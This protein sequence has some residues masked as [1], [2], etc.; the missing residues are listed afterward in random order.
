MST[1]FHAAIIAGAAVFVAAWATSVR[2][3]DVSKV[4][5]AVID[6]GGVSCPRDATVTA[7]AHTNEPGTV[8]F[9]IRNDS[10]GKTGELSA[11]AVKGPAGNYL[12]TYTQTFKI[13]A[14]VDINYMAEAVGQ[15]KLSDWVSFKATCGPQVRTK[16]SSAEPPAKKTPAKKTSDVNKD[17]PTTKGPDAEPPAQQTSTGKPASSGKPTGAGKPT[18]GPGKPVEQCGDAISV[19]RLAAVTRIGGKATAEAG[20]AQEVKKHYPDNWGNWN[21][22]KDRNTSCKFAGTWNCT[23][24]ARPCAP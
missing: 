21:N 10:G 8:K 23:A 14:D 12:A 15:G 7:W 5:L 1:V 3:L 9:V 11:A 18:A 24:S 4:E 13:T 20:W 16:K 2:A 17:E 6:N 19:T 22:A